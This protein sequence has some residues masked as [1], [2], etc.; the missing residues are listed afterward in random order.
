MRYIRKLC[1]D[2]EI[3]PNLEKTDQGS[4]LL[5]LSDSLQIEIK[6]LDEGFFLYSNVCPLPKEKLEDFLILVMKANLFFQ[7]TLG[8]T[9]ALKDKEEILTLS[10]AVPY[11]IN[12]HY[13]RE[14][15]EDFINIVEY[16]RE[17]TKHHID[18]AK[19]G[20]L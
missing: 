16:W 9:L 3:D 13:F 6:P 5:P 8:A 15:I 2:L 14:I 11:E 17:E 20:I 7:G 19:R 4:Y 12:D 1:E 10:R 18:L